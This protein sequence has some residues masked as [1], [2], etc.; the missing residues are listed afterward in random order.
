[1]ITQ[2]GNLNPIVIPQ[3]D[4]L[5]LKFNQDKRIYWNGPCLKVR[6]MKRCESIALKPSLLA[7]KL[8]QMYEHNWPINEGQVSTSKIVPNSLYNLKREINDIKML[9]IIIE[10]PI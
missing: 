6:K 1:M 7:L 2:H 5:V 8:Q 9:R 3:D 4:T 10:Q